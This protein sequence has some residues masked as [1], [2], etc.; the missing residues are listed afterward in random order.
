MVFPNP[1]NPIPGCQFVAVNGV[2]L[3]NVNGVTNTPEIIGDID[4]AVDGTLATAWVGTANH[5]RVTLENVSG[6]D[7]MM[8][9]DLLSTPHPVGCRVMG[10]ESIASVTILSV[11]HN[12][13]T[14]GRDRDPGRVNIELSIREASVTNPLPGFAYAYQAF[15]DPGGFTWDWDAAGQPESIDVL[16]VGGGGGG[17]EGSTAQFG[18]GGGGAGG[19]LLLADLP[20]GGSVTG[21]VGLGGSS[22]SD[23]QPSTFGA[24]TAAGGGAG[25]SV[26]TGN[27]GGSGGGGRQGNPGGTPISEQGNTGGIGNGGSGSDNVASTSGGAGGGGGATTAG[28]PGG[29]RTSRSG[30]PGGAGGTGV[31]LLSLGWNY[32][33]TPGAPR[34]VAGGGGGSGGHRVVLSGGAGPGF[35]GTPGAG[36]IGGGGQSGRS[37]AFA[38]QDAQPNTGGG[39]GAGAGSAYPA[40]AGGTGLVLVRWVVEP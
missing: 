15:F 30:G 23:G 2:W 5:W 32:R 20:V 6:E 12:P 28:G 35:G 19:V 16:M 21:S 38:G 3:P 18:Y 39:G 26:N 33:M 7:W 27:P 25:A 13:K 1:A 10:Q 8:L 11:V 22:G 14:R 17:G 34:Y 37:N 9:L 24:F 40:G 29:P 31:D 36:G 4:R